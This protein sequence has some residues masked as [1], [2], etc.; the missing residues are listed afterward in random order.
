MY[1]WI[2]L[3]YIVVLSSC[4]SSRYTVEDYYFPP[5]WEPQESVW[6]GW[7]I[8]PA[9]QQLHLQMAIAMHPY[10]GITI[11]ARSDSLL[12]AAFIQLHS[13]GID[14]GRIKGYVHFIPN[15]F[16][17]DAGPRFLRNQNKLAIADFGWNNYG[18]PPE[19]EIFQYTDK[20]G[21]IDNDLAKQINIDV[22]TTHV[23]AEGGGLDVSNHAIISFKETALQRNPGFSLAEIEKEYLRLYGKQKM[24][25]L[26]K[27]PVMDKV[28]AGPK[29][30]YYFG[31]GANGHIDEFARFVNDSTILI[32]QIDFN[33]KDL[34]P[35]SKVDYEIMKENLEILK[36]EKDINGKPYKIVILPT[37]SY[38]LYVEK[39]VLDET[40]MN[41]QNG[42]AFFKH[43]NI[44]DE[45]YWLPAVSY[46][47]FFITNNVVLLAKYWQEGLPDSERLK[48]EKAKHILQGAFPDRTII[49]LNP[50][51]LNKNGGGMNCATQQQPKIK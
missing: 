20:R 16:I 48:D 43:L 34:D 18:Y 28:L 10:V 8:S 38:S 17:R 42:K 32:S 4:Y 40:I 33:E 23:I 7:S 15:L 35:V 45:V 11:L 25:W 1:R 29:A 14:T 5:Q 26:N 36:K 24:I 46:A 39:Q 3:L 50:M 6:L 44:G 13:A 22:I 9:V 31:Y 51:A 37:P 41:T 12:K 19:F 21:D 30:G 49:Q 2:Y 47:N 27:M